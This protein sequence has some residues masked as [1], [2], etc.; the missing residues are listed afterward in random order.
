VDPTTQSLS[1]GALEFSFENSVQTNAIKV[2]VTSIRIGH[3]PRTRAGG[4]ETKTR[5]PEIFIVSL[6]HFRFIATSSVALVFLFSSFFC[7]YF[8]SIFL[9]FLFLDKLHGAYCCAVKKYASIQR[10]YANYWNVFADPNSSRE[11]SQKNINTDKS[12]LALKKK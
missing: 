2:Y 10:S 1:N 7:S 8:V 5:A 12:D 3:W 4:I 6:I 9:P 11:I